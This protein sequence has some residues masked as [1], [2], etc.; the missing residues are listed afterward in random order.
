APDLPAV[1]GALQG[2]DAQGQGRSGDPEP[3]AHGSD[4]GQAR[5]VEDAD[6]GAAQPVCRWH[7][8]LS[9]LPRRDVDLHRGQHRA[10]EVTAVERCR[11]G[12]SA[13]IFTT[14]VVNAERSRD[15]MSSRKSVKPIGDQE[16]A[17]L[18]FVGEAGP[19]TVGQAADRFGQARRLARSTVLTMMERLRKK[20]HLTRKLQAGLY[21][22]APRTTH[23]TA[24]KQAVK[25]FVDRT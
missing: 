13:A 16:L 8:G 1:G 9:G 22:Y 14:R 20:G 19:I 6:E 11:A 21:H 24:V 15:D 18:R 23:G 10:A 12:P 17:L 7:Q 5:S 25:T 4:S 3:P 2:G